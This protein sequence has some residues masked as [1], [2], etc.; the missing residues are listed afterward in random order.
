VWSGTGTDSDRLLY[1]KIAGGSFDGRPA[2]FALTKLL[3]YEC[4]KCSRPYYG[5]QRQCGVDGESWQP[6]CWP[7]ITSMVQIL[8][9]VA[10]L[11]AEGMS[12]C[13]YL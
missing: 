1:H 3:F 10:I 13:Q 7:S 2:D 12:N 11:V 5:G 9:N 6:R 8:T 4:H